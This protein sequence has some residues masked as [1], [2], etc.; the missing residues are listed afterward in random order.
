MNLGSNTMNATDIVGAL[1]QNVLAGSSQ[2]R[3]EH[4]LSDRGLGQS[5]GTLAQLFSGATSG[6]GTGA[7]GMLGG[8]A[9]KVKSLFGGAG[10]AGQGGNPL[11]VGGL[12][13][14]VGALLGGGGSAARGAL[15][16][17]AM[18]LLGSL[19]LEALQGLSRQ[20][21][22]S[23]PAALPSELPLGLR[24][25]ANSAEESALESKAMVILK[26]MINAAKADGQIDD[27]EMQ[28]I[29]GKLEEAGADAEAREFV[30]AEMRRPFDSYGLPEVADPQ[31]AVEV[32]AASVLAIEVDTP[33]EREY[34]HRL[35]QGLGLEEG[36][37]QRLHATLGVA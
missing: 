1:M 7:G 26:A 12:G 28:R 33:A 13:A 18:A 10:S 30:Q 5:G 19:A 22:G 15:G 24:G 4:A 27:A 23:A 32:Y 21:A 16:G 6:A 31:T 9:E 3:I 11:A 17:G 2:H 36:T 14:L 25:P 20:P 8:L 29:L 34:L 37:V 35:A